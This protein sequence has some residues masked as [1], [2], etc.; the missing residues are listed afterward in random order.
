MRTA[1]TSTTVPGGGKRRGERGRTLGPLVA[2]TRHRLQMDTGI[3]YGTKNER[4]P[5]VRM[6]MG[7]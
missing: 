7:K 1:Q 5:F 4:H 2:A 6:Q 3:R